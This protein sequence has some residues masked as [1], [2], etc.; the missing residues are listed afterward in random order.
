MHVS[1]TYE[2]LRHPEPLTGD[3]PITIRYHLPVLQRVRMTPEELAG[4]QIDPKLVSWKRC[5]PGRDMKLQGGPGA[6]MEELWRQRLDLC[7]SGGRNKSTLKRVGHGA[8]PGPKTLPAPGF[9][10][11]QPHDLWLYKTDCCGME[12][13]DCVTQREAGKSDSAQHA[14]LIAVL[15]VRQSL[16]QNQEVLYIFTDSWAIANGT[17]IWSGQWKKKRLEN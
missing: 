17:A 14:D 6:L 1:L 3:A 4:L 9:Q 5:I 13:Q 7:H 12:P 8:R 2:A 16:R 15:A 11:D 10:E